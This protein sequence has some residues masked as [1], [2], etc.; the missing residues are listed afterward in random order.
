MLLRLKSSKLSSMAKKKPEPP[1][2]LEPSLRLE[3]RNPSELAE[4]PKNWRRHPD[5]QISALT[6]VIGEVGWAG[7]CLYNEKSGRLIDGHAR[8]KVAMAQ[9]AEKIPVLIGSWD[10][11]Q[12]AKIL[13]TLDPLAAMAS[14]DAAALDALLRD[15]ETGSEAV[16]KMLAD[17]A[18]EAGLYKPSESADSEPESIKESFSILV[19]CTSESEQGKLLERFMAE[20]LVCRSLIS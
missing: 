19:E 7:A 20:G 8:Q 2:A 12:E 18:A 11:A 4:N 16:Q 6:D 1:P 10:E 14:T 13:A 9:G 15:V 17:L 5:A 3:W